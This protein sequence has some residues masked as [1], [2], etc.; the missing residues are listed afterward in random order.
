MYQKDF[1]IKVVLYVLYNDIYKVLI[2]L[3]FKQEEKDDHMWS[4]NTFEV[5]LDFIK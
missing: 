5:I 1:S 2:R 3:D 4:S